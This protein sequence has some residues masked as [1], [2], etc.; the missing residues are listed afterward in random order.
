MQTLCYPKPFP[1]FPK[2]PLRWAGCLFAS[3][4]ALGLALSEGSSAA[5][6]YPLPSPPAVGREAWVKSN[7][8]TIASARRTFQESLAAGVRSTV[9]PEYENTLG[10]VV[11]SA[12]R[13]TDK[14]YPIAD[15]EDIFATLPSYTR[16]HVFV[17]DAA[18]DLAE[19]QLDEL[20]LEERSKVYGVKSEFLTGRW[21]SW[22]DTAIRNAA[23]WM[24]DIV[25][26]GATGEGPRIYQPLA[27]NATSDLR[28]NDTDFIRELE[29]DDPRLKVV[30]FPYFI[31]GGNL[32]MGEIDGRLVAFIGA[33][34][35]EF[36][37][38]ALPI[39]NQ[40]ELGRD[41]IAQGFLEAVKLVTGADRVVVLPNSELVF[42]LDQ[43]LVFLAPGRVGV[44]KSVDGL[45]FQPEEERMFA[46]IRRSLA[47][48]GFSIVDIPTSPGH[49]QRYESS[50]NAL[51]FRNRE[52][53]RQTALV[54]RFGDA[55]VT[56]EG[57]PNQSLSALVAEVFR[58]EGFEVV[59]VKDA[60]HALR[61]NLHCVTL[62]L[63]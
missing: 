53:G 57:R 48:N 27:Y 25:L 32:E 29:S 11:F 5:S 62:P 39:L 18:V 33:N 15:F 17:P 38:A 8:T 46:E 60:F 35:V 49:L 56:W 58:R 61:G 43:A 21:K 10:E 6:V 42:H 41:A 24:R 45:P 47:D 37:I 2:I 31:R 22:S 44:L 54:P 9:R 19:D 59:Y 55:E 30:P 40:D 28:N 34:E 12:P 3:A 50:A 16:I 63:N 26:V 13:R 52:S 7:R 36:N 4:L 20:D 51:L 14:R 1:V 23:I